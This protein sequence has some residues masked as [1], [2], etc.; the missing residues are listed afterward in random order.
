MAFNANILPLFEQLGL[1]EQ[2]LKISKPC[3]G[4]TIY[5]GEL[6]LIGKIGTSLYKERTGYDYIIFSRPDMYQLILSQIP[7]ERLHLNK[8]IVSV[9]QNVHQGVSIRCADGTE[10]QGDILVGADGAYSTVRHHMFEDVR[11]KNELPASDDEELSVGYVCM[12]G[13]TKPFENGRFDTIFQEKYSRFE[14]IIMQGTPHSWST[15]TVPGNRVC[16]LMTTQLD[17]VTSAA[18]SDA[19]SEAIKTGKFKNIEWGP[20]ANE[21]VIKEVRDFPCALGGTMGDLI[22][23]TPKDKISRVFLE[24][25]L[26]ETWHYGRIVLVGDGAINA[27]QDAVIL[28]NSI[29][30]MVAPT[31][32]NI[33]A[34]FG[35]YR[36]QRYL[37]AKHQMDKARVLAT[38]QYGQA[39]P[40]QY[41]AL[42]NYPGIKDYD[43]YYNERLSN[44]F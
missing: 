20:E 8:K 31:P 44:C 11:Q 42:V 6:Q 7:S 5:D 43:E 4:M 24:E 39:S 40:P 34:A 2:V 21:A 22:D 32:E 25:K 13:T 29:V 18:S 10:H 19:K 23:A 16:W 12:V 36:E 37:Q 33:T 41:F 15:A 27:L 1:L 35:D 28:V 30:D 3:E 14:R 9:Q 17:T 38:I 26:F